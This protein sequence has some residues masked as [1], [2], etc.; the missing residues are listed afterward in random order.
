MLSDVFFISELING[1][2]LNERCIEQDIIRRYG[3][4]RL[5]MP[6]KVIYQ[7]R[8]PKTLRHFFPVLFALATPMVIA[9]GL[10]GSI[11]LPLKGFLRRENRS[12]RLHGVVC[13]PT[14][15]HNRLMLLHATG[16]H[17]T[18]TVTLR[19]SELDG[20]LASQL[21][22]SARLDVILTSFLVLARLLV[23]RDWFQVALYLQ[24]KDVAQLAMLGHAFKDKSE[25]SVVTDDHYQRWAYMFSRLPVQFDIVQHGSVSEAPI[26]SRAYGSLGTLYYIDE[27]SASTFE[28]IYSSIGKMV[29]VNNEIEFSSSGMTGCVVF[30]A[31]SLPHLESEIA[32]CES[33]KR[34]SACTLAVKLHPSHQYPQHSPLFK[35]A[36]FIVNP[37]SFI[38]CDVFVSYSSSLSDVYYA[39][40]TSVFKICAYRNVEDLV[41]DVCNQLS[42]VR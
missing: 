29:K 21:A 25:L 10:I 3:H 19:R 31:S 34:K 1:A 18:E 4:G 26:F 17:E 20:F 32:F 24:F 22:P 14:L 11:Y 27:K 33:L 2:M 41:K 28:E 30:L 35:L 23:A 42:A 37:D 9:Y 7:S 8:Y 6:F 13:F 5:T 15:E 38:E 40:G 39:R 16:L 36:D 12:Y